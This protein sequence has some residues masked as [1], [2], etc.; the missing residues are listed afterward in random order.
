MI[1]EVALTCLRVQLSDV[2]SRHGLPLESSSGHLRAAVR[3]CA[4]APLPPVVPL[5][6]WA[7]GAGERLP[8]VM[9]ATAGY[10]PFSLSL[11]SFSEYAVRSSRGPC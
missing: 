11:V 5:E 2:F 4:P 8:C 10:E 3:L 6:V 9:S 1:H 7:A